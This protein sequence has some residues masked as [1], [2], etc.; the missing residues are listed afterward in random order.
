M[1]AVGLLLS[2]HGQ[3]LNVAVAGVDQDVV[4]VAAGIGYQEDGMG[5]VVV[6]Y[7]VQR[8]FCLTVQLSLL[9]GVGKLPGMVEV[10]PVDVRLQGA[11]VVGDF[12]LKV[13]AWP[14]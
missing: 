2:Q 3:S 6:A 13:T 4:A 11:K 7:L 10:K 1:V 14:I 5:M 9:V 12:H 8:L